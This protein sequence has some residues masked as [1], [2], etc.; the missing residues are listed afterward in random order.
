MHTRNVLTGLLVAALALVSANRLAAADSAARAEFD[1][2]YAQYKEIVKQM[3]DLRDRFPSASAD[4]RPAMDKK[5]NDLLKEGNVLRP[6]VLALAEKAYVEN[7]KEE[8]LG[9]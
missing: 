4:E 6:K 2:A 7:P 1:K 3:Y 5:F 8:T 9:G